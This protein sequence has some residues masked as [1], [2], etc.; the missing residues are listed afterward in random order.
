[1]KSNLQPTLGDAKFLDCKKKRK[2]F[3]GEYIEKCFHFSCNSEAYN[4]EQQNLKQ[5]PVQRFGKTGYMG[6]ARTIR[7]GGGGC[8][9]QLFEKILTM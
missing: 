7:F 3:W 2:Q 9:L 6:V 8:I 1:M 4:R 5:S